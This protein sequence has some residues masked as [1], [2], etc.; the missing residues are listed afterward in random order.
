MRALVPKFD[1]RIGKRAGLSIVL[2]LP[3]LIT[4]TCF[5]GL[6]A[7]IRSQIERPIEFFAREKFFR[8]SPRLDPRIKILVYDDQITG[9]LNR[10]Q[11]NAKEWAKLI[12]SLN[13]AQPR[14]IIIDQVF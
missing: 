4:L 2:T 1:R 13:Q 12:R 6:N 3:I 8:N 10:P 11:L 9:F 7:V 14:A 5:D